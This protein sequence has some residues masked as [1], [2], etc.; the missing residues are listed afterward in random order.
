[1][2]QLPTPS[3]VLAALLAFLGIPSGIITLVLLAHWLRSWNDTARRTVERGRVVRDY[4][5]TSRAMP[6][7]HIVR[8]CAVSVL[9]PC[10]QLFLL[11]LWYVMGQGLSL[12]LDRARGQEIET[13]IRQEG[14]ARL[15]EPGRLAH[16]LPMNSTAGACLVV[17]LCVL[18]VAYRRVMA[19]QSVD[20]LAT[21]LAVAATVLL[22][23]ALVV[24]TI[25]ALV[26]PSALTDSQLSAGV[27]PSTG[28]AMLEMLSIPAIG[29]AVVLC[30]AACNV[31]VKGTRL[32]VD[33]WSQD[34]DARLTV[35]D[36]L[37]DR[38]LA[39][40]RTGR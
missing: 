12:W 33:A 9:V 28:K 18:V 36:L 16:L 26:K 37:G 11:G 22:T 2:N 39:R 4:I 1:M 27:Q 35:R 40:N 25:D 23:V 13:A 7:V 31:S 32:M 29:L 3:A 8:A 5:A 17:C 24:I 19:G 6:L 20:R 15:L 14:Y 21:G 38:R 34:P 10:A 30:N